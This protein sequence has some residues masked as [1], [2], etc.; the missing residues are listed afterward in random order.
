MVLGTVIDL[1]TSSIDDK[2]SEAR[3][4]IQEWFDFVCNYAALNE[5]NFLWL[6][7]KFW[8]YTVRFK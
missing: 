7:R 5:A 2:L 8:M 4:A 1:R 3:Q 6:K